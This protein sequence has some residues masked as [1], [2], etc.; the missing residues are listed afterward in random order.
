MPDAQPMKIS[1]TWKYSLMA[2]SSTI[3]AEAEQDDGTRQPGQLDRPHGDD[4]VDPEGL[5]A[6]RQQTH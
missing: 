6:D 5:A 2:R 1:S 3:V 4:P